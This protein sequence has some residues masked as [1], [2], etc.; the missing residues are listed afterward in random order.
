[1]HE[2]FT[3]PSYVNYGDSEHTIEFAEPG[4]AE[5]KAP[6]RMSVILQASGATYPQV[7]ADALEKAAAYFE[8]DLE[9]E[10]DR[11]EMDPFTARSEGSEIFVASIAVRLLP[12]VKD[13]S[14]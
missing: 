12:K 8:L 2:P 3:R 5:K 4:T 1:M 14:N 7:A 13:D 9:V 11:L 6:T 10:G